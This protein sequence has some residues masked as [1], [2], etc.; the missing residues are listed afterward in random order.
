M[1]FSLISKFQVNVSV[2]IFLVSNTFQNIL[3]GFA[4]FHGQKDIHK[5]LLKCTL[6]FDIL[7]LFGQFGNS[8]LLGK[9][10]PNVNASFHM[11]P[12][13]KSETWR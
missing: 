12:V 5:K 8:D 4:S 3:D 11:Y 1:G 13:L 10:Y 2:T 9:V 7:Q 6:V